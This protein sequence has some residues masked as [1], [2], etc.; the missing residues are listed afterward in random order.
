M[1]LPI[2][3]A[4]PRGYIY[5]RI[6]RRNKW[7]RGARWDRKART[8]PVSPRAYTPIGYCGLF[9]LPHLLERQRN[10]LASSSSQIS[11]SNAVDENGVWCWEGRGTLPDVFPRLVRSRCCRRWLRRGE[12]EGVAVAE[13]VGQEEEKE[14]GEGERGRG[15]GGRGRGG[16]V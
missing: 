4:N 3:D 9:L 5:S 7:T 10:A 12:K 2:L 15:R 8:G 14:E 11:L 6:S 16:S 1:S 13:V